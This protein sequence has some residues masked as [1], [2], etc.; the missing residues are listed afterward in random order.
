MA[1]VETLWMLFSQ[2]FKRKNN[3]ESCSTFGICEKYL[4]INE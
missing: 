4:Y 1:T 3:A 2:A